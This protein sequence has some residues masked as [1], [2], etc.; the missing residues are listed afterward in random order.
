MPKKKNAARPD[1]LIPVKV[2]LGRDE[3]GTGKYKAVYGRTQREADDKAA[4][5]KAA[6]RK[7]LDVGAEHE[8]FGTWATRWLEIKSTEVSHGRLATYKSHVKHLRLH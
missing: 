4:R 7:G 2:Y 8:T 1:G 6:L 3:E 5:V